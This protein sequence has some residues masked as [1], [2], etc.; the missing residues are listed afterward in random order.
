LF[1]NKFELLINIF[2]IKKTFLQ[3]I[4]FTLRKIT[5]FLEKTEYMNNHPIWM[6]QIINFVKIVSDENMFNFLCNR[7]WYKE[8]EKKKYHMISI[9]SFDL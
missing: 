8:Q 2:E 6:L 5:K 7:D 3:R 4:L 1:F 9:N